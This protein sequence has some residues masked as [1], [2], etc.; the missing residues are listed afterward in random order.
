MLLLFHKSR[1]VRTN[2]GETLAASD[3]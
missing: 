2:A 1:N 3:C